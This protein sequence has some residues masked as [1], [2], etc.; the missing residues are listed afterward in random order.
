MDTRR[1]EPLHGRLATIAPPAATSGSGRYVFVRQLASSATSEVSLAVACGPLDFQR[2]VVLKRVPLDAF[3]DDWAGSSCARL[4]REA[5]AYARLSH[6]AVVRLYDFIEDDDGRC[7]LVMEHVEGP[8][9]ARLMDSLIANRHALDDRGICY[10]GYRI[11]QALSAAHSA[12]DPVTR[13]F[14]PVIHRGVCPSNVLVPWDG[15]VKLA[16]FGIARLAGI[17][18]GTLPGEVRGVMGYLAPEQA[19]GETA[20][21]RTDVYAA[22]LMMHDL[23]LGEPA[24]ARD[25]LGDPGHLARVRAMGGPRLSAA[26]NLSSA[27]PLRL[28][29]ALDRGLA[30]DPEQRGLTA[31]EMVT[32]LRELL[33][34]VDAARKCLVASLERLRLRSPPGQELERFP[35]VEPRLP[36]ASPHADGPPSLDDTTAKHSLAPRPLPLEKITSRPPTPFG[37]TPSPAAPPHPSSSSSYPPP[38]ASTRVRRAAVSIGGIAGSGGMAGPSADRV[39]AAIAA[40]VFGPFGTPPVVAARPFPWPV[41]DPQR[42]EEPPRRAR[43]WRR[44]MLFIGAVLFGMCMAGG[45]FLA[46]RHRAG[47]GVSERRSDA[48]STSPSSSSSAPSP[49]TSAPPPSASV[50]AEQAAVARPAAAPRPAEPAAVVPVPSVAPTTGTLLTDPVEVGHRIF[51]D[52]RFAGPAGA[53]LTVRCGWHDVRVGSAGS[54]R[55][56]EVPCGGSWTIAR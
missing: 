22:C 46:F 54:L 50:T 12:R 47:T 30:S 36:D 37:F 5:V 3:D 9:L 11:F 15:Y 24:F 56:V 8:T 34:D 10:V 20:T 32:L 28:V 27:L 25:T 14:A 33:G 23:F 41:P 19:R 2:T 13:E 31:D 49:A 17:S 48:V 39:Q 7:T 1:V 40:P 16:D 4:R 26:T 43:S 55:H 35:L 53:P 51:V 18:G 44:R 45:A 6:P 21:V 52:G 42:D 29:N 38:L